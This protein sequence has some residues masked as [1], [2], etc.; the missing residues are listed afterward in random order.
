MINYDEWK[1]QASPLGKELEQD[2]VSNC[3]G[4][5]ARSEADEM[6]GI[7]GKCLEHC[8]YVYEDQR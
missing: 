1:L 5:K 8:E 3:C 2:R 7:C 4:V 6:A